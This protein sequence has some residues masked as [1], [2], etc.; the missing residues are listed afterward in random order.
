MQAISQAGGQGKFASQIVELHREMGGE[1]EILTFDLSH[2]RKGRAT[3]PPV[4][5]GDV[6]IVRRRFF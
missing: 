6:L 4:E 2:I 1:K 5:S 3:D